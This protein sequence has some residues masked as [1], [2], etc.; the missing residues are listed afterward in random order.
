MDPD[1][2]CCDHLFYRSMAFNL[3]AITRPDL[4]QPL[5]NFSIAG[6]YVHPYFSRFMYPANGYN[7]Q[8]PYCYRIVTPLLARAISLIGSVSIDDGFYLITV[9]SLTLA[10][11]FLALAVHRLSHGV[12]LALM[13]V[14]AY[15]QLR[16][17]FAFN[18]TQPMLTDPLA[19]CLLALSTYLIIAGRPYWFV[20]VC[21]MGLFNKEIHLFMLP[22]GVLFQMLSGRPW[23]R[24]SLA[25]GG[26]VAFYFAFRLLLPVPINTY[27]LAGNLMEIPPLTSVVQWLIDVF[28]VMVVATVLRLPRRLINLALLPQALGAVVIGIGFSNIGPVD[29]YRA[30]DYAAPLVIVATFGAATQSRWAW[31]LAAV[32]GALFI[33]QTM[34]ALNTTILLVI[35]VATEI[36]LAAVTRHDATLDR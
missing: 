35:A 26:I 36:A 13:S 6:L 18:L 11:F 27:S 2:Y 5:N 22:C 9:V 15:G 10:A 7:R 34:M 12:V 20:A 21:L 16:E 24:M 8:P 29:L 4:N 32:P 33:A 17:V 19:H 23:K 3:F 14:V 30:L 31:L 1:Q 25:C 28:G